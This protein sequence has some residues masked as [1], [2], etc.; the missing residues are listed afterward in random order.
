[1][2]KN[3]GFI[4]LGLIIAIIIGIVVVGGGAY[5]LGNSSKEIKKQ[6]IENNIPQENQIVENNNLPDIATLP[7]TYGGGDVK[8]LSFKAVD[9]N[10]VVET[11]YFNEHALIRVFAD[12]TGT[13]IGELDPMTDGA[14]IGT[15]TP[16]L[17]SGKGNVKWTL[18][19]SNFK[20][21]ITNNLYAIL[22][23]NGNA[24][25]KSIDFP[26]PKEGVFG[27]EDIFGKNL[28][29]NSL[30]TYTNSEYGFSFNYPNSW[31][32]SED[33]IKKEVTVDTNDIA[34]GVGGDYSYPSWSITFKATDK[35]FFNN[36]RVSTKYGI[37]TYDENL[38]ALMS[39][40]CLKAEKLLGGVIQAIRYGGSLM[41]DPAYSNSA[42]L[43]SNGG[44][45]IVN[46][47]QGVA[48]T[49]LISDQLSV[50]ANSFKLLN[51]NTV[52]VPACAK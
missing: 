47:Y 31:K 40:Q 14:F 4:G 50:I 21:R 34:S 11:D 6:I 5:Y 28:N 32:L 18:S 37:I 9:G 17:T 38:K 33:K 13:G 27:Y 52:F 49:P 15:M 8:L 44:I 48:I 36:N 29:L 3:K 16:N 25:G 41:S 51:G 12:P 24:S 39:D 35:S 22:Y 23:L 19:G 1:M 42:I 7:N 10:F 45:I 46:S 2:N 20:D 30:K 26:S 43:T